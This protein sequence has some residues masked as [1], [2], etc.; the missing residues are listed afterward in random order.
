VHLPQ[1]VATFVFLAVHDIVKE[2]CTQPLARTG[3]G[4]HTVGHVVCSG[5]SEVN[6]NM[7]LLALPEA[8]RGSISKHQIVQPLFMKHAAA[9]RCHGLATPVQV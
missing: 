7:P 2:R 4:A 9:R 6:G 8:S 3:H 5:G 1:R